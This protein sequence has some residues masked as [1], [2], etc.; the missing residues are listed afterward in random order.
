M[1]EPDYRDL[2]FLN[3]DYD[4]KFHDHMGIQYQNQ[5]NFLL[6]LTECD[7]MIRKYYISINIFIITGISLLFMKE[8]SKDLEIALSIVAMIINVYWY[9]STEFI[10]CWTNRVRYAISRME[11]YMPFRINATSYPFQENIIKK[12]II[13]RMPRCPFPIMLNVMFVVFIWYRIGFS[14]PDGPQV[15]RV[16]DGDTVV[17]ADSTHVRLAGIDAPEL[18][19]GTDEER[20]AARASKKY[21]SGLV[22][23]REVRVE[24]DTVGHDLYGRL[25]GYLY[26]DTLDVNIEML[27]AG[28]AELYTKYPFGRRAEFEGAL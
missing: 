18:R 15:A 24:R 16:I 2:P 9:R 17:L 7:F 19:G 21:L 5:Y 12:S 1:N 27:R 28:H 22:I 10:C 23:G 8:T 11:Q 20:E 6:K 13:M 26:V 14:A 3:P 4:K 25:L